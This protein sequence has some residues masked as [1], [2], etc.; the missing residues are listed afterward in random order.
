MSYTGTYKH[1][2]VAD[3]QGDYAGLNT[4]MLSCVWDVGG[5]TH[6]TSTQL[7]SAIDKLISHELGAVDNSVLGCRQ[8]EAQ[9]DICRR[10][11]M[12][13][14]SYKKSLSASPL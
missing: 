9:E 14:F 12:L 13:F 11:L 8:T 5:I 2:H 3:A 7:I 1:A 10:S 4:G 6:T